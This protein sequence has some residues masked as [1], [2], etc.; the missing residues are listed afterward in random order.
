MQRE[1]ESIVQIINT[2][3][4]T[5]INSSFLHSLYFIKSIFQPST[6]FVSFPTLS[7]F[8]LIHLMFFISFCF[9]VCRAQKDGNRGDEKHGIDC[10]W[11][12]VVS[13]DGPLMDG[14]LLKF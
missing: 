14:R 8:S 1:N 6:S 13:I 10:I 12:R 7:T 9:E 11:R 5:T 4:N 3:D 2:I